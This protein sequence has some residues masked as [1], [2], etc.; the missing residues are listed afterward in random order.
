MLSSDR[1][2]LYHK[3]SFSGKTLF[4]WLNETI[5]QFDGI[6]S[7]S[8]LVESHL[9]NNEVNDDLSELL[10]DAEQRLGMPNG[11]LE[12]NREFTVAIDD[13]GTPVQVYLARFTAI[14]TPQEQLAEQTGKFISLTEAR[15]LLPTELELLRLAYS[16]IMDD[17]V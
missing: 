7:A 5:C 10:M 4:L 17:L 15:H 13:S 8:R 11:S 6:S 1:L 3:H 12:I 2:I 9:G 14:D 16:A